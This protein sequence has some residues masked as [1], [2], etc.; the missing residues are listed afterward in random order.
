MT[1]IRTVRPRRVAPAG[2]RGLL[3]GLVVALVIAG[4]SGLDAAVLGPGTLSGGPAIVAAASPAPSSEIRGDPRS[5]GQGAG[6]AGAPL[7]AVA[8]VIG[9][10][11][12]AAGATVVYVRLTRDRGDLA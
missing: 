5:S 11:V 12:L 2:R 10:G 3:A 1:E 9:L 4:W 6:L 7:L 8:A